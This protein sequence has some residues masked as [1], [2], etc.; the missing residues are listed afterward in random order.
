MAMPVVSIRE[1]W[2]CVDQGFMPV[3]MA[4]FGARRYRKIMRM[5]VVFVVDMLVAVFHLFV[6]VSVLMALS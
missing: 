3:P 4:V 1:M 2:V 5:L 6:L